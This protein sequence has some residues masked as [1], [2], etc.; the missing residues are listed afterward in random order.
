MI[1][2]VK[3]LGKSADLGFLGLVACLIVEMIAPL[4]SA[5]ATKL[6]G[7]TFAVAIT[8][9]LILCFCM[10]MKEL[11]GVCDHAFFFLIPLSL[12]FCGVVWLIWAARLNV[13]HEQFRKNFSSLFAPG[14]VGEMKQGTMHTSSLNKIYTRFLTV[15]TPPPR[16]RLALREAFSCRYRV[17]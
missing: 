5:G 3:S 11:L 8:L 2:P 13:S 12:I 10:E 6:I 14:V 15:P 7:R 9:G 1:I 17:I 4:A 16:F